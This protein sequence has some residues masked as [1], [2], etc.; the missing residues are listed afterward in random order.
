MAPVSSADDTAQQSPYQQMGGADFF[1]D[2]IHEFY[3]GVSADAELRRLYPEADLGPAERRFR[4]FLEQYWGGP[5][6][7]SEERGH[8]RLRLRHA[9]FVIDEA[10]R[11]LW[12]GHMAHALDVAGPRHD[13]GPALRADLW[14]YFTTG[15]MAM[16]N[17]EPPTGGRWV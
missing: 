15:S 8:P 13:L 1:T 12:L 11:D 2:L 6:T 14:R 4:M 3:A 10:A 9:P 7:Y 5:Q 16:V 17:A